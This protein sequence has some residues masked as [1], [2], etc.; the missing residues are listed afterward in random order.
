MRKIFER[1][2]CLLRLIKCKT[3]TIK[4]AKSIAKEGDIAI[5]SLKKEKKEFTPY[6][7]NKLFENRIKNRRAQKCENSL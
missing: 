7:K 6:T 5:E 2:G 3:R 1:S 4:Y